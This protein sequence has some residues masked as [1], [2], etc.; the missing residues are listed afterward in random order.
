MVSSLGIPDSLGAPFG[1][2][3]D[4]SPGTGHALPTMPHERRRRVVSS[5]EAL[6]ETRY[7]STA[8]PD[9]D[10]RE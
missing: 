2:A 7:I 4:S 1:S 9:F 3:A 5:T 8:P 10:G 6:V